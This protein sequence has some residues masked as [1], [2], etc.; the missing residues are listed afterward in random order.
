MRQFDFDV[1]VGFMTN[2]ML[3]TRSKPWMDVC[4]MVESSEFKWHAMDA[5]HRLRRAVDETEA[6]GTEEAVDGKNSGY[7]LLIYSF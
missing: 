3:K 6:V 2:V 5:Q 4:L 7:H 1:C